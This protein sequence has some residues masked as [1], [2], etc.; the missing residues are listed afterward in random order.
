MGSYPGIVRLDRIQGSG[1]QVKHEIWVLE[2]FLP[3]M[4][5][6]RLEQ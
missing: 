5:A 3:E 6:A 2:N 1:G 4:K